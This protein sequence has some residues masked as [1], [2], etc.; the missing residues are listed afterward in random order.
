MRGGF[1]NMPVDVACAAATDAAVAITLVI[2]AA[3]FVPSRDG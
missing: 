3:G 1:E 2:F